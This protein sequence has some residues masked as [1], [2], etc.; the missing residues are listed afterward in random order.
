MPP[1]SS[2]QNVTRIIIELCFTLC[3][4]AVAIAILCGGIYL[5][6]H[7]VMMM[8]KEYRQLTKSERP[9][10]FDRCD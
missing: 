4:G 3:F 9:Y 10:P 1:L 2:F 5:L 7:F 8:R 6:F